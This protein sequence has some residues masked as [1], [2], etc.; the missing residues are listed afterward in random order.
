MGKAAGRLRLGSMQEILRKRNL[1]MGGA[2]QQYIDN[3]VLRLCDPYIPKDKGG[4]IA[5]GKHL[6]VP[7]SGEVKWQTGDGKSKGYAVRWY[8]EPANFQGAPMRGNYWF[9]RMKN[10]GGKEAIGQG[11]ANMAGVRYQP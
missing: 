6:T 11:A 3:E 5:S 10:E 4:L 1:E 2:V 7:G 9:E 8:Y